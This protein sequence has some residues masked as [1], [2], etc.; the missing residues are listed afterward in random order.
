MKMATL[1][2]GTLLGKVNHEILNK[3]SNG[4]FAGYNDLPSNIQHLV[5]QIN[6][7][8]KI[9]N[10]NDIVSVEIKTCEEMMAQSSA[11]LLIRP[12]EIFSVTSFHGNAEQYIAKQFR[13]T[14]LNLI[15]EVLARTKKTS[16]RL[17]NL[18]K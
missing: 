2:P 4:V 13:E 11:Q 3:V 1:Y 7:E 5:E 16:E 15:N 18:L 17:E 9:E 6:I 14:V 10:G 8:M 12:S